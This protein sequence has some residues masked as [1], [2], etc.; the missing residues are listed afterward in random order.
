MR[1]RFGLLTDFVVCDLPK[2]VRAQ[3]MQSEVQFP[4]L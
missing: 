4:I 1:R 2:W 3:V